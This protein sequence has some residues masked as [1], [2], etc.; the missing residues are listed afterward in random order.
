VRSRVLMLALPVLAAC[1]TWTD[2]I[3][4]P[5]VNGLPSQV[6]AQQGSLADRYIVVFRDDVQN[7]GA[8]TDALVS[9]FGGS[10]HFRYAYAIKGFAATL[11]SAAIEGIQRN[12]NVAFIESDGVATISGTDFSVSSWGLDR[13]DQ[14]DLPLSNSY[15]W[16]TDGTGVRAYILDTGILPTHVEFGTRASIGYD[17]IGDGRNGNDCHGHGTH[18]A[19]T[20]GGAEYGVARGVRLI[21]VRVLNCA[22]SGSYSQIIAGVD[23][24]RANAVKPATANMSLGG[25]LSSALNT[26]VNNAVNAGITFVVA[27]GNSSGNACSYSPAST[28]AALTIGSTTNSDARS[29]FSNYGTCVDLFAPGSS[30]PSAYYTSNTA[31]VTMS[32]TSMASPHVAGVAAL[33]LSGNTTATPAQVESAIK[34]GATPNK[35]TNA[36]IGSPNLLLYNVLSGGSPPPPPPPV[37]FT[38]AAVGYKVRSLQKA[39]LS[40]SGALGAV[41][42]FRDGGKIA[43]AVSGPYTDHINVKGGGVSYTYKVCNT[44]TTVCSNNASV[45]F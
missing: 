28:P 36:G 27:A 25:G 43:T 26:A 12:T 30:I 11:P 21:A 39:D 10:V 37:G 41:D 15:T 31:I 44:G 33:Y 45:S 23:W 7:P 14:R 1:A 22:G 13:I 38:L 19:G 5:V 16:T 20:V 40:W 2:E 32:G 17:A 8:L 3:A 6:V 4:G 42:V 24:V 35:V 34:G 9:Q 18:V 29:S